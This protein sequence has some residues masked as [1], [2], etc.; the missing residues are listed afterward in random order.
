MMAIYINSQRQKEDWV[1]ALE[2]MPHEDDV[3]VS[4]EAQIDN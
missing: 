3:E 4:F 1:E 2:L